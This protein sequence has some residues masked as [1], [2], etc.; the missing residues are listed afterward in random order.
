[1][2]AFKEFDAQ[3]FNVQ[4]EAATDEA[5]QKPEAVRE[6]TS[7]ELA[8]VGGGTAAVAFY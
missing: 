7:L 5:A 8:L 4:T 2:Q 6:L 1:M 3:T